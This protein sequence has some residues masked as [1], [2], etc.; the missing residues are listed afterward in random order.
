MAG[1]PSHDAVLRRTSASYPGGL[2]PAHQ[3]VLVTRSPGVVSGSCWLRQCSPWSNSFPPHSPPVIAPLV[4]ALRRYYLFVRL[5]A[6]V[7]AGLIA[8]RLL[9]PVRHTSAGRLR[10]LPVLTHEVSRH[11]GSRF[12]SPIVLPSDSPNIGQPACAPCQ[13]FTRRLTTARA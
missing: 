10:G 11:A 12:S 9:Q 2:L 8:R 4:R 6:G 7:H 3:R 5:P 1:R 13:R